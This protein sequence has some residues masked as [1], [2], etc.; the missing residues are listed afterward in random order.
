MAFLAQH[1]RHHLQHGGLIIYNHDVG[2]AQLVMKR[3]AADKEIVAVRV[4]RR[5]LRFWFDLTSA[6][7]A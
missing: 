6:A 4:L 3:K 2:H 1:I 5:R 7:S